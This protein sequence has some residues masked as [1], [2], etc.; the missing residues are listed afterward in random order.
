MNTGYITWT[1]CFVAGSGESGYIA[2]DPGR[3]DM[4]YVGAIGSSPGAVTRCSD[5]TAA[6]SDSA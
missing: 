3:R 6:R 1:D 4:L 5:M 2:V